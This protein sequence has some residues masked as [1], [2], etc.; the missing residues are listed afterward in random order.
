MRLHTPYQPDSR[1]GT[2]QSVWRPNQKPAAATLLFAAGMCDC[3][4]VCH[5][6]L[7][8]QCVHHCCA[9]RARG[10]R[11]LAQVVNASLVQLL[12]E[13]A[14]VEAGNLHG[15]QAKKGEP[16]ASAYARLPLHR[17]PAALHVT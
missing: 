11:G 8:A 15:M 16:Q 14:E 6:N 5:H 13:V 2:A 7:W 10:L 3:V 1:T 12:V 4:P 17:R 9:Q